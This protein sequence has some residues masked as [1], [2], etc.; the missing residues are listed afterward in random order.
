MVDEQTTEAEETPEEETPETEPEETEEES[1]KVDKAELDKAIRR[2]DRALADKRK[3]EAELAELKKG[4]DE[5]EA[6]PV[7][8]A[9][10]RLVTASARTVL[11]GLGI[12]EKADQKAVLEVLRLDDIDVDDEGPDEDAI[13]ER[14]GELRRIFGGNSTNG[15]RVPRSVRTADRGAGGGQSDPDAAR[16]ARILRK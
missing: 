5:K 4:K 10:R 16:Y 14:I 1:S 3:L 9:N 12:A 15:K 2:R 6:D 11:A 7:E 13:E 8:V